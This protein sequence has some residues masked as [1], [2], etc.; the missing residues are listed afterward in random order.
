MLRPSVVAG[1]YTIFIDEMA[2]FD[3]KEAGGFIEIKELK[4][5]IR[6]KINPEK[7]LGHSDKKK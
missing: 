2:V 4:K 3:R 1:R 5:L 6:D 7:S